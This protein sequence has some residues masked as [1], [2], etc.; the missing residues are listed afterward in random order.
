M[1]KTSPMHQCNSGQLNALIIMRDT[2]VPRC[3]C[4]KGYGLWKTN[5]NLFS[6]VQ[7]LVLIQWASSCLSTASLESSRPTKLLLLLQPPQIPSHFLSPLQAAVVASRIPTY[8]L[9][10]LQ[11]CLSRG[12]KWEKEQVGG[13]NCRAENLSCSPSR[14][15]LLPAFLLEHSLHRNALFHN[16][17]VFLASIAVVFHVCGFLLTKLHCSHQF[18]PHLFPNLWDH[19]RA[20]A[21]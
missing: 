17:K 21:Q 6:K 1:A 19:H 11:E 20:G 9:T 16:A 14:L 18:P 2:Y 15:L 7:R 13:W 12:W 5:L 8:F 4:C 10:F 3:A